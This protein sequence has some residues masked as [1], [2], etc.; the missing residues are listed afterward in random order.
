MK[1]DILLER[2]FVV[3]HCDS[4]NLIFNQK[5]EKQT[6][7]SLRFLLNLRLMSTIEKTEETEEARR[8]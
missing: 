2:P 8:G 5:R 3:N 1:G 6:I 7:L 4:Q